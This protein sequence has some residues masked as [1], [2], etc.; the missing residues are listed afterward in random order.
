M[1]KSAQSAP[2]KKR[3]Y[4]RIRLARKGLPTSGSPIS[5]TT[6]MS[7]SAESA[8]MGGGSSVGSGLYSDLLSRCACDCTY[9]CTSSQP[10]SLIAQLGLM[11]WRDHP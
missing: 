9:D 10:C 11:R 4:W 1:S 6:C 3:R 8:A 7:P 5:T 2:W